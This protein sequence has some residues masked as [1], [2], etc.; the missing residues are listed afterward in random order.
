MTLHTVKPNLQTLHGRFS[1]DILPILTIDSGDIVQ[2]QTLDAGWCDFE[3]TNLFE[4]PTKFAGRN[5]E[6]DWG[7]RFADRLPFVVLKQV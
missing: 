1:R 7:M 5:R 4:R 6:F 2:Y 3:Q